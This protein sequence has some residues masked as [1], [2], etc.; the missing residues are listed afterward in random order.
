VRGC[1]TVV[2]LVLYKNQIPEE[3]IIHQQNGNRVNN[4]NIINSLLQ[5]IQKI[6][7]RLGVHTWYVELTYASLALPKRSPQKKKEKKKKKKRKEKK[8]R[9]REE[10]REQSVRRVRRIEGMHTCNN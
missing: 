10:G 2:V 5:F 3:N 4:N 9:R 7:D 6:G 1:C 8:K